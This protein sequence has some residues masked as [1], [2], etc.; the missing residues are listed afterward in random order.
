MRFRYDIGGGRIVPA[1]SILAALLVAALALTLGAGLGAAS[2]AA[3]PDASAT[4][5]VVDFGGSPVDLGDCVCC[6]ATCPSAMAVG[7]SASGEY[8]STRPPNTRPDD[9]RQPVGRAF[10]VDPPPPK[11]M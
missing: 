3:E 2:T 6:Y 11:P 7:T 10:A 9:A 1:R 5:R 8:A 4:L